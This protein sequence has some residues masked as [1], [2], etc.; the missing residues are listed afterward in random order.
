[1][2]INNTTAQK[3]YN[4]SMFTFYFPKDTESGEEDKNGSG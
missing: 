2:G 4:I 3:V 1:M